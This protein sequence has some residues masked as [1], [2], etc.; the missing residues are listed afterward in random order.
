MNL[1]YTILLISMIGAIG[2]FTFSSFSYKPVSRKKS[3]TIVT[4]TVECGVD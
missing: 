3:S 4:Y 1:S 2:W